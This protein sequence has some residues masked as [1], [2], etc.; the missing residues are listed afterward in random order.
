MWVAI[1]NNRILVKLLWVFL[2]CLLIT[3]PALAGPGGKIASAAFETFWGRVIL[4]LITLFFLPIILWV[5]MIEWRAKHRVMKDLRFMA[6]VNPK[7]FD[8]LKVKQRTKDCFTRVHH[9]WQDEDLSETSQWMTDW[10]WQNQQITALNQWKKKGLVNI[11]NVKK[12][13]KISPVYFRHR[14]EDEQAHEDSMIVIAIEAYMQDYLKERDTDKIVE[15]SK[16]YKKVATLWTLCI[17]D[18]Q[19][20]VN[21]IDDGDLSLSYAKQSKYLPPIESTLQG[22]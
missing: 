18:G 17:E 1:L 19:W 16:R 3:E 9:G 2:A 5:T 12:I 15:G 7:L 6:H 4:T 22:S 21:D 20:K 13:T 10:Y 8:W 14:N 11:C